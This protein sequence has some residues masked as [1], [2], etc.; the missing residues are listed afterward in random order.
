MRLC[1]P[2]ALFFYCVCTT[3]EEK[4][5]MC[6]RC[7]STQMVV[8]VR[9]KYAA[10][11]AWLIRVAKSDFIIIKNKKKEQNGMC[12]IFHFKEIV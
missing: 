5:D 11:S 1:I 12:K 10:F 7:S 9:K 8:S 3:K 6:C 4:K 2:A